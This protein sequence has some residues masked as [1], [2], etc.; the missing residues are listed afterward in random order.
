M[1]PMVCDADHG[2]MPCTA[3]V[4]GLHSDFPAQ[5]NL[6]FI[7]NMSLGRSG[8]FGGAFKDRN[9]KEEVFKEEITL[10]NQDLENQ[11][12]QVA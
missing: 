12:D 10:K 6:S 5:I 3:L 9:K 1:G 2:S 8:D 4:W 11:L 7:E